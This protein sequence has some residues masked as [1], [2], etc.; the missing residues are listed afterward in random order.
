[1][2]NSNYCENLKYNFVMANEVAANV[3]L[4]YTGWS[5]FKSQ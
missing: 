4:Q 5:S 2:T 1:M 3:A